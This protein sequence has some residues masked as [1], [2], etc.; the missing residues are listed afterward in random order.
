V[1]VRVRDREK[2][3]RFEVKVKGADDGDDKRK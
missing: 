1:Y 3:R 2:D